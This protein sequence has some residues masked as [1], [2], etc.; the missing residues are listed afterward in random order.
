PGCVR[1]SHRRAPRRRLPADRSA[2]ARCGRAR[3]AGGTPRVRASRG[4]RLSRAQGQRSA[5]KR[6]LL[7]AAACAAPGTAPH[8]EL[9]NLQGAVRSG[10]P[11]EAR[12][13]RTCAATFHVSITDDDQKPAARVPV[14]F[15]LDSVERCMEQTV[16]HHTLATEPALSDETGHATTCDPDRVARD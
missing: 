15:E 13:T 8:L 11:V 2:P 6:L 3:G 9:K 5:V 14:H 1:A 7:L 10:T 16:A 4:E 12:L